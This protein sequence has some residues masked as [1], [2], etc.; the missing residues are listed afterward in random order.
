[1]SFSSPAEPD[2]DP[3]GHKRQQL[4]HYT[5]THLVPHRSVSAVVAVGS[6]AAGLARADSDIDA[7][8]FMEPIDLHVAPAE[9]IWRPRDNTYHSIFSAQPDLD[10]GIQLDFTRL[11]L[12]TWRKAEHHWPEHTRAA[13]ADGWVA[14][15]RTGEVSA[16]LAERT[17]MSEQQRRQILDEVLVAAAGLLRQ[18][19]VHIWAVLG[20]A[21][22]FDRLQTAYEELVRGVFAYNRKWQPWR[23]RALRSLSRLSY[24]PPAL[25]DD[26][27]GAVRSA[28]DGLTAYR[29]R[30]EQLELVL[31]QLVG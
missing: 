27:E 25:G 16:L 15:D 11:D 22:A 13:L 3:T 6:V 4:L 5:R 2:G 23:G 9:A 17:S 21:E 26:L 19:S 8:I 30:S 28:G 29:A 10:D 31:D 20:A 1:M 24:L 14:F 7:T 18:D 12:A